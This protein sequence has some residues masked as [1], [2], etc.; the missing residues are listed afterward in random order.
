MVLKVIL[1]AFLKYNT[2]L[3]AKS[4]EDFHQELDKF[5]GLE[6]EFWGIYHDG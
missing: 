4:E 2:H 6:W 1:A 3:A 5:L